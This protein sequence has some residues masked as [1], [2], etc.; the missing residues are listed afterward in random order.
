MSNLNLPRSADRLLLHDQPVPGRHR[1]AVLRDEEAGD[2]AHAPGEG[3]LPVHLDA[4]LLDQQLG[5]QLVLRRD[6]QVSAR[7]SGAGRGGAFNAF[8]LLGTP[9]TSLAP[10]GHPHFK[11]A[12]RDQS[13]G[14]LPE[15]MH[16]WLSLKCGSL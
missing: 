6:R 3:S 11:I 5:A 15:D 12:P 10:D 13:T 8:I 4:H 16:G 9:H 2:G 14:T 1:H 7:G